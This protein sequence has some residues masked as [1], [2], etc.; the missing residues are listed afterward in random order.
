MCCQ[1][2]ILLSRSL[3]KYYTGATQ[4]KFDLRLQEHL[5]K[6]FEDA[7]T[8]IVDDWTVFLV[9]ECDTMTQALLIEKHIKKMKS[10]KYIENLKNFPEMIEKLRFKYGR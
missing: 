2:Y 4:R 6:Y 8:K 5:S 3:N 9:I 7:F 1:V 10:K